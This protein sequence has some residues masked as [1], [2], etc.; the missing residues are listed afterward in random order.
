MRDAGILIAG[1]IFLF[2]S[3][4]A[5]AAYLVLEV[6]VDTRVDTHK[7]EEA[8]IECYVS[9]LHDAVVGMG[10]LPIP[11][12]GGG[13]FH[14]ALELRIEPAFGVGGD[15]DMLASANNYDCVYVV[16]KHGERSY[17]VP[18]R[19]ES[20]VPDGLEVYSYRGKPFRPAVSG[21]LE[22]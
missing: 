22:W 11:F 2:S 6:Y 8:H 17:H 16:K 7:V 15:A 20:D 5:T 14:G 4:T 9:D 1:L 19:A 10:S 12:D 13:S 3:A 21:L 18:L